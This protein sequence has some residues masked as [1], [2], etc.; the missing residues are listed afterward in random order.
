MRDGPGVSMHISVSEQSG[1]E[2]RP[3]TGHLWLM[4]CA[5]KPEPE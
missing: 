3:V 2:V 5:N 1:L 4:S